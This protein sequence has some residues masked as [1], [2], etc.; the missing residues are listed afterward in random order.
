[1]RK[2]ELKMEQKRK[3]LTEYYWRFSAI[4]FVAASV[5]LAAMGYLSVYLQST[6]MDSAQIGIIY[7]MNSLVSICSTL[8]WGVASDKMNSV[9]RALMTC[10]LLAAIIWPFVPLTIPIEIKGYS[11]AMLLIP[12]SAFVRMPIG[13]LTDNWTLQFANKFHANYGRIRLWGTLGYVLLGLA[14][15]AILPFLGVQATFY[16]YSGL[17]IVVFIM[18]LFVGEETLD[19]AANKS[20]SL[21]DLHIGKLFKNYYF[22]SYL[23]FTVIMYCGSEAFL[24]YLMEE[25]GMNPDSIG[26]LFSFRSLLE[27]PLLYLVTR[28][29]KRIALPVFILIQG[30]LY[31]IMFLCYSCVQGAVLFVIVTM[32]QGLASGIDIGFG[33]AYIF[34]LAPNELKS[35]AHLMSYAMAYLAGMLGSLFGGFFVELAGIRDYYLVIGF[36]IG[37]ALLLYMLSFVFGTKVLKIPLPDNVRSMHKQLELE[38]KREREE[39]ARENA[40]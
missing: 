12:L 20:N 35:T 22:V 23:L 40:V 15:A 3:S 9:R 27:M 19:K 24:P 4:E 10:L 7:S 33:S 39:E 31:V 25:V 16:I 14:L 13:G 8:F 17:L 32:L 5:Y 38:Q 37:G 29:R 36:T 34:A 6:G 18:A 1:M 26:M 28:L 30:S 11:L 2:E 21:K